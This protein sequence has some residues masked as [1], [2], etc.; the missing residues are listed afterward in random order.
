MASSFP[1]VELA[2][3]V[4]E[5]TML[6]FILSYMTGEFM[7]SSLIII[8]F[9]IVIREGFSVDSPFPYPLPSEEFDGRRYMNAI[10]VI[11]IIGWAFIAKLF[12][13]FLHMKPLLVFRT[14]LPKMVL[15]EAEQKSKPSSTLFFI[16]LIWTLLLTLG[17]YLTYKILINSSQNLVAVIWINVFPIA[18]FIGGYI[19][20]RYWSTLYKKIKSYYHKNGDE[21]ATDDVIKTELML[22]FIILAAVV[23][24]GN[25]LIS[26]MFYFQQDIDWTALS[27]VAYW[28]VVLVFFFVMLWAFSKLKKLIIG[29]KQKKREKKEQ[30]ETQ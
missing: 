4:P 26:L 14:F 27:S 18:C 20:F 12:I 10:F 22:Y 1:L 2:A 13:M 21:D 5:V 16:S 30:D 7:L 6:P 23:V 19:L 8:F 24:I 11:F 3:L 9:E 17:T 29:K 28:A 25:L 15:T